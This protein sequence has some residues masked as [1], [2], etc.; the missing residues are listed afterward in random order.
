[1]EAEHTN[2]SGVKLK[3]FEFKNEL[4]I[5][6]KLDSRHIDITENKHKDYKYTLLATFLRKCINRVHP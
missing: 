5:V 4:N 3:A 6:F 2:E 1:M